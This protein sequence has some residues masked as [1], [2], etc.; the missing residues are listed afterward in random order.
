MKYAI[1]TLLVF[2][3]LISCTPKKTADET[4][5]TI[6]PVNLL[7]EPGH[8]GMKL[9]WS[10]TGTGLSTGYR[11]YISETPLAAKY[12]GAELPDNVKSFNHAPY[13]GDTNPDDDLIHFDAD[14]LDNGKKYYVSVRV[15]YTNRTLSA[16][17]N[18]VA[19]VCGGR[20]SIELTVRYEG[21]QDGFSFA[22]NEFVRAD[23]DANDLYFYSKEG[24]DY[25][26]SPVRLNGF[27]RDSKFVVLPYRGT[28]DEVAS[29]VMDSAP[30]PDSD[31]IAVRE[32]DWVLLE[33]HDG[34]HVLLTLTGA[35]GKDQERKIV[36]DYAYCS[37]SDDI[38]F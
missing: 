38:W 35:T 9:V 34:H 16:P 29:R 13:P 3:L 32:G 36:L 33:T 19:V 12:P 18:E 2:G 14:G 11:I 6:R 31:R 7:V 37:L 23:A 24:T 25:L 15:Q 30:P 22:E 26:A 17:S 8:E 4:G 5:A 10:T 1:A 21:E 28:Y 27:L 20:G